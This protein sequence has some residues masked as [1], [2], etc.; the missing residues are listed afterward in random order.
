VTSAVV[1]WAGFAGAWLL[2]AGP[3]YQ[4][5]IELEAEEI[6]RDAIRGAA[7]AIP[8]PPPFSRWWWLIPPVGYALGVRRRRAQRRELMHVLT[9]AQMGQLVRYANKS[10]GWILIASGAFLVALK[11]TWSPKEIYRWPVPVYV[12]VVVLMLVACA[13]ITLVRQ[14]RTHDIMTQLGSGSVP[15]PAAQAPPRRDP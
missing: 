3:V 11:E 9:P 12:L 15:A 5:A 4:A 8:G 13:L 7:Q 1:A 2:V 10:T 6:E 14:R